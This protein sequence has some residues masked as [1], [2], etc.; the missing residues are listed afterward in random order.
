M[1]IKNK[2]TNEAEA[3]ESFQFNAANFKLVN[4]ITGWIVFVVAAITYL[5]TLEPTVS[6]W[7]CGEFI[8]SSFKMEVGHPPGAPFF[9]LFAKFFSLFLFRCNSGSLHD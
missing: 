8:T 3:S 9:M 2:A 4:K 6:F 7:D 5:L 1:A